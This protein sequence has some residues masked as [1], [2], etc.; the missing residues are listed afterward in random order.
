MRNIA[1]AMASHCTLGAGAAIIVVLGCWSASGNTLDLTVSQKG[2]EFRPGTI[3]VVTVESV[4]IVNDD[5]DLLHHA[6]VESDPF[7]LSYAASIPR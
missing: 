6:Y 7:N 2:R 1:K 5:A 4:T 3:S